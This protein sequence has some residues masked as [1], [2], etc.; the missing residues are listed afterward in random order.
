M[1]IISWLRL[2]VVTTALSAAACGETATTPSPAV[3]VVRYRATLQATWNGATH[4]LD[5]PANPHFSP[6]VGGTHTR[7]V[8]FWR[9]ADLATEGIQNMAERGLTATLVQEIQAAVGRGTARGSFVGSGQFAS[10][11][12]ASVE[13]DVDRAFPLLTLV[14]MIAPSPDWFVGVAGASLYDNGTWV[15]D[16]S[17]D[18][19][20]WDAGSDG[21][22]TFEAPDLPLS[23]HVPIARIVTAPLSPGGKVTPLGR[24]VVVRLP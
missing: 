24:L 20:P 23:P 1:Q 16:L 15:N 17:V 11:G 6:L 9:E 13:F 12:S 22:A 14:S 4:P 10:P 19:L 3:T 18:L 7:D 5:V 8:T 21:G 2:A